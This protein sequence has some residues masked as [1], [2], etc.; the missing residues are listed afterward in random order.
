[1]NAFSRKIVWYNY[2]QEG[3]TNFLSAWTATAAGTCREPT[4]KHGKRSRRD[5]NIANRSIGLPFPDMNVGRRRLEPLVLTVKEG[6]FDFPDEIV[7]PLAADT[8]AD[9]D[10][11]WGLID[12]GGRIYATIPVECL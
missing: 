5:R 1:M 10:C 11:F 7:P 2:Q 4:L 3:V 6:D 12:E 8:F 9:E